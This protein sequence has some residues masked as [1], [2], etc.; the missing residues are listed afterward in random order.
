MV[1]QLLQFWG[2]L[3]EK[4]RKA[5]TKETLV[6]KKQLEGIDYL[7]ESVVAGCPMWHN[8]TVIILGI[9]YKVLLFKVKA[10]VSVYQQK[11]GSLTVVGFSHATYRYSF[12][13]I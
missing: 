6:I 12:L 8:N 9:I 7:D 11:K 1:T 4:R 3:W 10:G 2:A 5:I 13:T